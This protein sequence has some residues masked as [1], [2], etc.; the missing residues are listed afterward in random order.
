MTEEAFLWP[1]RVYYEAT[2]A[3]GVVYHSRY[4]NFME[5]ARTEWLRHMG[6]NQEQL[7]REQGVLFA[8]TRMEIR[9]LAPARLDDTLLVSVAL[10]SH[11][12][13]SL[14]LQQGIHR[15]HDQRPLI[16]A[17]VEIVALNHRFKPT[18]LP[19]GL[20]HRMRHPEQSGGAH[21]VSERDTS[22]N[23]GYFGQ[24][25]TNGPTQ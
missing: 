6:F 21:A 15:V 24:P 19:S 14:L 20:L 22:A 4:L 17:T 3:G 5:R 2:D 11:K 7:H 18:R 23:A 12:Q 13:A 25:F 9:F 8:V 1:V 16:R 10:Q